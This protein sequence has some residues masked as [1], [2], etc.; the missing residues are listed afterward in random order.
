MY[1]IFFGEYKITSGHYG[2]KLFSINNYRA[3]NKKNS[4]KQKN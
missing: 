3:K 4:K 2:L 1:I